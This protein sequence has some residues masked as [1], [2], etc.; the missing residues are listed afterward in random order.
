LSFLKDD[1]KSLDIVHIYYYR[2]E[3]QDKQ[4]LKSVTINKKLQALKSFFTYLYKAD[5]IEEDFSNKMPLLKIQKT[6]VAPKALEEHEINLLLQFAG[7]NSK[8]ILKL[9]N[10]TMIQ[11]LLGTGIRLDELVNLD[12]GDITINDRSGH[13][14]IRKGKGLKERVVFL[15]SKVRNA[16]SLYFDYRL[17]KY[18][19]ERLEIDDPAISNQ[20]NKRMSSRS[21]Q[22]V[23]QT[24]AQK[25]V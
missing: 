23:I 12:Y 15:N 17:E 3:L 25:H 14:T 21:V 22:K 5:Y 20:S 2:S 16:L 6:R 7:S 19:L 13:L 4:K 10:Y 1:L 18:S 11:L 8:K 24:L 9:R